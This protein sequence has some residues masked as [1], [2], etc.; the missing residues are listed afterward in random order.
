MSR[1]LKTEASGGLEC[2]ED[3]IRTAS[4]QFDIGIVQTLTISNLG[5]RTIDRPITS[6]LLSLTVLD[7]SRNNLT[8]IF[9]LAPLARTLIRLD[10]SYN[11]I[12]SVEPLL[13]SAED[14]SSGAFAK[15]EVLRFQGNMVRDM[16]SI[17]QLSSKLPKLR[18][19]Y[20]RESNCK[21]SNPLCDTVEDYA[22][23]MAK[24]FSPKC[25]CI[26][27]HYF[28]HEDVKP[29]RLDDGNDNEITLP[30]SKSW[31][32]ENFFSSVVTEN[33]GE[34]FGAKSEAEVKRL[35][36]ETKKVLEAKI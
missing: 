26:D 11:N 19:I 25:R 13:G 9:G 34:K 22:Q 4:G 18:A 27:G 29:K 30:L 32:N 28:C 1:F 3:L 2:T 36:E 7:I 35:L 14:D 31:V 15:L 16:G 24:Y 8:S 6:Q 20:F 12:I 23:Q 5:I 10:C 17:A 33:A 21:G